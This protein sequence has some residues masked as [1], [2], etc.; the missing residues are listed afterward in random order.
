MQVRS[1]SESMQ[2]LS[3]EIN[4]QVGFVD[5]HSEAVTLWQNYRLSW[6]SALT[7]KCH[8]LSETIGKMEHVLS[9]T[10]Q[11]STDLDQ[12]GV[13]VSSLRSRIESLKHQG[14]GDGHA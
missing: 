12:L 11:R 7:K 5:R 2:Q 10:R 14:N 13:D 3:R 8:E 6:E 1:Q 4:E 9:Q